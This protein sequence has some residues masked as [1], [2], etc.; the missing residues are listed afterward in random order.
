M[1]KKAAVDFA[2]ATA[3]SLDS[4]EFAQDFPSQETEERLAQDETERPVNDADFFDFCTMSY[5]RKGIPI[6][7]Y[8]KKNGKYVTTLK[9]PCNWDLLRKQF[10]PGHYA[11]QC[12]NELTNVYMKGKSEVLDELPL[13]EADTPASDHPF[14]FS[15]AAAPDLSPFLA[16]MQSQNDQRAN[17][18]REQRIRDEAT[19]REDRDRDEARRREDRE[20]RNS[21]ITAIIPALT[22]LLAAFLP[23]KDDKLDTIVE[24]MK[25]S[26]RNQQSQNE[27]LLERL[28]R[29]MNDPKKSD[30][31]PLA[32]IKML[33]EAKKDGRKEMEE[34]LDMVEDRASRRAEEM[35]QSGGGGEESTLSLLLKNLGPV[36]AGAMAK[37]AA[38]KIPPA[39]PEAV[40]AQT[41]T[42]LE[43]V[44]AAPRARTK[45]DLDQEAIF[46]VVLPFFSEQFVRIQGGAT[47]D[48]KGASKETLE[49]LKAQGFTR[50]RVLKL[51]TKDVLF[52]VLKNYKIPKTYDSWFNEY[53]AALSEGSAPIPLRTRSD[54]SRASR[55][56]REQAGRGRAL[57]GA[58][59]PESDVGKN[60]GGS[61]NDS[62]GPRSTA[63]DSGFVPAPKPAGETV[64]A[65]SAIS[66][67]EA[68][69]VHAPLSS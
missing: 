31:D 63:G 21:L 56:A 58:V 25:D 16:M 57:H 29:A 69:E 51:F 24:F 14:G 7:F 55:P 65:P 6:L 48:P 28:E 23:K 59:A 68:P 67:G 38:G 30:L 22:P 60:G 45:D 5:E 62:P 9:P 19:R 44:S 20:Q 34:L 49:L 18:D 26:Q 35:S 4:Q 10:G 40:E 41:V 42:P 64:V 32:M 37:D 15:P 43:A 46:K 13:Q 52:A 47:V 53:Y 39:Q 1:T 17:S 66:T 8:I 33:N 12:K 27:K 50:E 36:I 11:V 2:K 54:A 3:Q 61:R